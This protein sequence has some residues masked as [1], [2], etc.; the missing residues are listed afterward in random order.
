MAGIRLLTERL[1]LRPF[2]D[3]DL[4]SFVAYRSDPAVAEYQGWDAPY[5]QEQGLAFIAEMKDK[6]PGVPGDWYQVAV[7]RKADARM[8][9]DVAFVLLME[10]TR[11]AEMGFTFARAY[12]GQGYATEAVTRLLDYLFDELRLHR[13]RANCDPENLASAKLLER[14]GMRREGHTVESLRFKG[15]WASEYW[16][17]ILRREWETR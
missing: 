7:Q 12:H 14:V 13:V 17:A 5:S 8:I 11:Q 4:E 1:V 3:A 2:E 10:D 15:R 6:Q 9:G 16:Y